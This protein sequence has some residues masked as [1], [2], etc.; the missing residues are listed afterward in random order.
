MTRHLAA[1]SPSAHD[2]VASELARAVR[3]LP[4][5]TTVCPDPR[6]YAWVAACTRAQ[7]VFALARGM[8]S[9]AVRLPRDLAQHALDDGGAACPEIGPGWV[10]FDPFRPDEPTRTTRSRV[11]HWCEL[12]HRHAEEAP[13]S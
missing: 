5:V 7:R 9:L 4:G 13:P 3:K 2:D 12:A 8:S 1:Q 6:R 11:R 10:A